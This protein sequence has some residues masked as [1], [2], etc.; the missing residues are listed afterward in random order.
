MVKRWLKHLTD[1]MVNMGSSNL[2]DEAIQKPRY[3]SKQ[4]ET[5]MMAQ[6]DKNELKKRVRNG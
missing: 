4:L 1:F 5:A 2:Q 6:I 3:Q